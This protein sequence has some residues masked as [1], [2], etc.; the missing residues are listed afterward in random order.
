MVPFW[1]RATQPS[2]RP[3]AEIMVVDTRVKVLDIRLQKLSNTRGRG[4]LEL[5]P[6]E[7]DHRRRRRVGRH[8]LRRR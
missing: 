7:V 6:I 8:G 2:P 5:L 3:V 4:P 1:L